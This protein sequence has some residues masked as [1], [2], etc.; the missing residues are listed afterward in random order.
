MSKVINSLAIT[1]KDSFAKFKQIFILFKCELAS[2]GIGCFLI[3]NITT[4]NSHWKICL[5]NTE[6]WD[7]N[8]YNITQL[9]A[10]LSFL[11]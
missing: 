10:N 6:F 11:C 9:K 5:T 2:W 7:A 8:K 4:L 1:N 3:R